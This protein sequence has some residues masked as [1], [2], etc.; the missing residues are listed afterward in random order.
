MVAG[1]IFLQYNRLIW[2]VIAAIM[3]V[4][5]CR[6]RKSVPVTPTV[7]N[8]IPEVFASAGSNAFSCDW[9]S[10]KA[11]ISTKLEGR[12]MSF[13]A[14]F[15][16]RPDS[17]I[18][19]SVSPGLG[20]EVVRAMITRDSVKVLDR[21]NTSYVSEDFRYLKQITGLDVNFEQLQALLFGNILGFGGPESFTAISQND[22]IFVVSATRGAGT[23]TPDQ[24][25]WIDATS[26]RIKNLKITDSQNKRTME[27]AFSDHKP[28]NGLLFPYTSRLVV[29]STDPMEVTVSWSKI[30][31]N[32]PLDFP[33]SIPAKYGKTN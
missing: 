12:S 2:L 13:S 16:I 18:W 9:F 28:E 33:F 6:A 23:K 20:L 17:V 10:G 25:Y 8:S 7:G 4:Q 15:R 27:G 32:T 22:K 3:I 5:G 1:T 26:Y 31:L 29:T 24:T 14:N 30:S 21:L 11:S 19:V